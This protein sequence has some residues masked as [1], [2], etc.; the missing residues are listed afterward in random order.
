MPC[1]LGCWGN[2]DQP[3]G[4]NMPA[5]RVGRQMRRGRV[6]WQRSGPIT[7]WVE[8]QAAGAGGPCGGF[9]HAALRQPRSRRCPGPRRFP[10]VAASACLDLGARG[11]LG[12]GRWPHVSGVGRNCTAA[13]CTDSPGL[14]SHF[15]SLGCF[16]L[17][18]LTKTKGKSVQVVFRAPFP[19]GFGMEPLRRPALGY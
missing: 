18:F 16:L 5:P 4:A 7:W 8:V 14:P 9:P 11:V 2:L 17:G 13:Q 3:G 15:P 19:T 6:G 12:A 1:P 10:A